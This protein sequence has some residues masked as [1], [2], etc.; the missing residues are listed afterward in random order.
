[1]SEML[2]RVREKTTTVG[3][4]AISLDGGAA[5]DAFLTIVEAGGISGRQYTFCVEENND[6][7]QFRGIYTSGSPGTITRGEVLISKIGGV[8]GSS[9]LPLSGGAT[10]RVI[11]AAEDIITKQQA[12]ARIIALG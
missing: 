8:S 11:Q 4:G 7:E 2:N 3:D 1:M 5:T 6:F 9:H 10:I 12:I